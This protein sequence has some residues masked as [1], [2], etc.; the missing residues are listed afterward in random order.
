MV[1]PPATARAAITLTKAAGA[2]RLIGQLKS[3]L[4]MPDDGTLAGAI[5]ARS[6]PQVRLRAPP[7][8]A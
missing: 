1:R 3:V 8:G 7:R 6:T 4:G 5:L 2:I